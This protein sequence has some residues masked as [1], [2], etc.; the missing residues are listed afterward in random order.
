MDQAT[1]DI[2]NKLLNQYSGSIASLQSGS[3][4]IAKEFFYFCGTISIAVFGFNLLLRRGQDLADTHL[5][6]IKHLIYLIFLYA[7][8]DNFQTIFKNAYLWINDIGSYL[9]I[10]AAQPSLNSN[11]V[12]I[13]PVNI[14]AIGITIAKKMLT[15]TFDWNIFR[16]FV[17]AFFSVL[18]AGAVL[19]CFAVIGLEL[20]LVQIG[21]QIILA[22]GI[23]LLGFAGLT[24]AR[25]YA[26]R[27][28][29]TFFHVGIKM[30]FI[31]VLIG[32]GMN[33]SQNW[34][35]TLNQSTKD[36]VISTYMAVVLAAYVYYKLCIKVPDQ[37]VSWLTGRLSMGFDTAADVK[38]AV[39]TTRKVA[40]GAVTGGVSLMAGVQGMSK[41]VSLATGV[42]KSK[43]AADGKKETP[44]NTGWETIKTLGEASKVEWEKKVDE[45]KGGKLAKNILATIPKPKKITTRKTKKDPDET[46][47]GNA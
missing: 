35:T 33:L 44:F 27:Y 26:E 41:A 37:A 21:S 23:F 14:F 36:Q 17:V 5:E 16:V 32:I 18:C 15:L 1:I 2:L 38:E 46:M 12:A 28:V 39:N 9:G 22:G 3:I 4:Y 40:V 19:F 8:I 7:F 11:V 29:H 47:I 30:I 34:V 20:I 42:A 45:T 10:Q 24:W 25:E 13:T 31:N 6:L 43:I